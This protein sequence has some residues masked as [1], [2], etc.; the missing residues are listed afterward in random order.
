MVSDAVVSIGVLPA[1][2]VV[3]Q[4]GPISCQVV[5]AIGFPIFLTFY[6][7][8]ALTKLGTPVA[9]GDS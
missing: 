5:I 7:D 6:V 4:S 2:M 3:F 9:A 8:H 1:L